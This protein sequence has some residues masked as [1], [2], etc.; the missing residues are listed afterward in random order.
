ML[1]KSL[2]CPRPPTVG[3]HT[4]RTVVASALQWGKP[5]P[6]E[7]Q[8]KGELCYLESEFSGLFWPQE[9]WSTGKPFPFGLS[10]SEEEPPVGR[11]K[12]RK[13]IHAFIWGPQ[14]LGSNA[15]WLKWSWCN[16]NRNK[17][18]N[19]CNALAS[20]GGG[21]KPPPHPRPL[22]KLSSMKLVPGAKRLGTAALPC[23]PQLLKLRSGNDWC[24]TYCLKAQARPTSVCMKLPQ[25][26]ART[27]A[28]GG[29]GGGGRYFIQ[30]SLLLKT[31]LSRL[32]WP[33][34]LG[35][36]MHYRRN[37]AKKSADLSCIISSAVF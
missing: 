37:K 25:S 18:H 14:P 22:E 1:N 30:M 16:D 34:F 9:L 28:G 31:Q 17:V 11:G 35:D 13:H 5:R 3:Q 33:A 24:F 27:G 36:G 12:E 8:V 7:A 15:W 4:L 20:S 19:K 23:R 26:R 29:H 2:T 6:Q 21:E 32:V 10:S